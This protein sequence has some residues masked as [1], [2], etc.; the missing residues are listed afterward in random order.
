[1]SIYVI[2]DFLK[3]KKKLIQQS[4]QTI[5]TCNMKRDHLYFLI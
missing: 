1:M 2:H 4:N 3:K 5:S